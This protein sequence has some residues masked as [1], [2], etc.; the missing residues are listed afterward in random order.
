MTA[1]PVGIDLV[2]HLEDIRCILAHHFERRLRRAGVDFDDAYQET[3]RSFLTR[4]QLKGRYDP[5]RG[6]SP[7]TYLFNVCRSVVSNMIEK[8]ETRASREELGGWCD[9]RLLASSDPLGLAL[10]P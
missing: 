4:Q 6:A 2:L 9:A 7:R 10:S 5:D 1:R 8:V 3:C